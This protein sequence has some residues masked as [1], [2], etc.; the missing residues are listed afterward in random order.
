MSSN[1]NVCVL[2]TC[3]ETTKYLKT[4][5]DRYSLLPLPEARNTSGMLFGLPLRGR[6][7]SSSA[8][9]PPLAQAALV[10]NASNSDGSASV[11][12]SIHELE[13]WGIGFRHRKKDKTMEI[14]SVVGR[15]ENGLRVETR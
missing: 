9:H 3:I 14:Q 5:G 4:G 12:V 1:E 2:L 13:E 7:A 10:V 11:W 15:D 6:K 8:Q